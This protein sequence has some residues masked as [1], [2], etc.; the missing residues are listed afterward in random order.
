VQ[1]GEVAC[2]LIENSFRNGYPGVQWWLD[3]R[4]EFAL[5]RIRL[6][7]EDKLVMQVDIDYR[8]HAQFGWVPQHWAASWYVPET[9]RLRESFDV[10]I[11]RFTLNEPID[12]DRFRVDYPV[13]TI[14]QENGMDESHTYLALAGGKRREITKEEQE[15]GLKYTQLLQAES[16]KGLPADVAG[17]GVAGWIVALVAAIC[18][19]VVAY[20]VLRRH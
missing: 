20:F 17:G 3:P 16:G 8:E 14:V 4:H 11:T 13:G 15:Q 5:Q 7:R 10:S 9:G 19:V 1:L 2:V 18:V 6:S 12:A